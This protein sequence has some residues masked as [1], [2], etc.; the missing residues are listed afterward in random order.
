MY[1]DYGMLIFQNI[2][3]ASADFDVFN[4]IS[5]WFFSKSSYAPTIIA[6]FGMGMIG[7]I[8]YVAAT[9]LGFIKIDQNKKFENMG[10]PMVV[11]Y[12]SVGGA[13][14]F[15][16]QL[17]ELPNFT[18]IQSFVLG[19]IW[20]LLVA[21]YASRQGPSEKKENLDEKLSGW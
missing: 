7:S 6:S 12:A 13:V 14:S 18:P 15:V 10:I 9:K 1:E 5:S 8:A 16:F 21:Q 3:L 17:P 4:L 11:G 20:P 2:F 19:V